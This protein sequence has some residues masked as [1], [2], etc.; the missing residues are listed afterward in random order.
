MNEKYN[1]PKITLK[2]FGRSFSNACLDLF[3]CQLYCEASVFDIV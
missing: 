3:P 1:S 2:K